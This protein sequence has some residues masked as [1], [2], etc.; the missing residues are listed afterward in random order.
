ML[1]QLVRPHLPE[2]QY[3]SPAFDQLANPGQLVSELLVTG[4]YP[5]LPWLAYL[6]VGLAIGR[7]D[8]R[9][10]RVHLWLGRDRAGARR[11]RDLSPA[12]SPSR[13]RWP[14]ACSRTGTGRD[15]EELLDAIATGM[16]GQTPVDGSWA[17]LLVVAP[18]TTTPFDLAQTIGSSLFVIGGCL[19]WSA[20]CRRRPGERALAIVFGAGTM[21]LTLYS[22]HV[23]MRTDSV[24]PP[25]VPGASAGTCWCCSASAPCSSRP[26]G[27]ARSSGCVARSCGQRL[28]P[29]DSGTGVH[30]HRE[31]GLRG[32]R[33]NAASSTTPSWNQTAF[34]PTAT[35]WSANSPA[36]S[37]AAEHVDHVDRERNVR[38]RGVDLLVQDLARAAS[39][40]RVDGHDALSATLEQCRD[41]EGRPGRV[42]RTGRPPPRSRSRRA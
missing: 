6:L 10:R 29:L 22:L 32:R 30:D 26:A 23:V 2:R 27:A 36:A 42:A 38:E 19:G 18:H 1:S 24:W 41:R 28:S 37:G 8:L 40:L 4:Y 14:A 11:G 21:T 12:R 31:P 16:F 39:G 9:R 15:H 20:W 34:A 13:T 25:E 3:A 17:W 5:C 35:A 33:S 7:A